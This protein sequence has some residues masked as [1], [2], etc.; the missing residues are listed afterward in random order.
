MVGKPSTGFESSVRVGN[1][2][3]V[4][5][6]V[7]LTLREVVKAMSHCFIL[8]IVPPQCDFKQ[9]IGF[10]LVVEGCVVGDI[11]GTQVLAASTSSW[12][13]LVV[14]ACWASPD[15]SLFLMQI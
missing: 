13:W 14:L 11:C 2:F 1:C 5:L 15:A 7:Y 6:G 3:S 8:L 12:R 9:S 10:V 4:M